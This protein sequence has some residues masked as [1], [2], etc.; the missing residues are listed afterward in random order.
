MIFKARTQSPDPVSLS[1][2]P[3]GP[4]EGSIIATVTEVQ[5]SGCKNIIFQDGDSQLQVLLYASETE[6]FGYINS[7]PHARVPLNLFGDKFMDFSGEFLMCATHGARFEPDT[8]YC[9]AGPCKGDYLRPVL[10]K[11]SGDHIIAL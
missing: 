10:I 1:D 5:A 4:D 3:A 11:Q 2:Y 9:V 8:G 7:C 6:I